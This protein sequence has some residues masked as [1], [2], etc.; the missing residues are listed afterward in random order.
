[1]LSGSAIR[2][3]AGS[4]ARHQLLGG[5]CHGKASRKCPLGSVRLGGPREVVVISSPTNRGA[6][7]PGVRMLVLL[8]GL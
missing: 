6:E 5:G 7:G 2:L 8:S 1:M 3:Q 4:K